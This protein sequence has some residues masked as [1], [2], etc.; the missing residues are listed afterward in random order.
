MRHPFR[1]EP[2]AF[3]FL[4]LTVVAFAIV[5][6]AGL[7]G[8]WWVGLP[9]WIL[10]T[11][12]AVFIYLRAASSEP[13]ERIEPVSHIQGERRILVVAED[14]IGT[15]ALTEEI[16]RRS[17]GV[18]EH[19]LVV[20][21]AGASR[22]HHWVSDED[23]A[24]TEA[25]A[26]VDESLARLRAAGINAEGAVGD[27]D[28]LQAIEDALRTFGADEIVISTQPDGRSRWLEQRVV[29][30]ARERFS[31]PVTHVAMADERGEVRG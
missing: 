6:A 19:V 25:R 10:V 31:P 29:E 2:E 28:P 8:G 1:S 12:G 24:R 13:P 3:N 20:E 16:H 30:V 15:D 14:T 23:G 4:L 7:L 22:L 26:R 21:P 18:V 11:L 9:V 17:E 5:A 27:D